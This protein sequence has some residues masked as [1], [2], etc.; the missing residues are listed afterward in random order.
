M[1]E[2]EDTWLKAFHALPDTASLVALLR[3]DTPMPSGARDMMAGLLEGSDFWAGQ[4]VYKKTDGIEKVIQLKELHYATSDLSDEI[5][6]FQ[7]T[8]GR[9]WGWRGLLPI[10]VDYFRL[11]GKGVPKAA[12]KVGER[13]NMDERSIYRQVKAWKAF[14]AHLH[15]E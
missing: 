9:R 12:N 4:L 1:Y 15:R 11:R 8:E 3:S 7:D 13:Y 6:A 5:G 14:L 2:L 10:A